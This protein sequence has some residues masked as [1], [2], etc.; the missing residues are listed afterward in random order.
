MA[1]DG[2][3]VPGRQRVEAA[4]VT[5]GKIG[6]DATKVS[7]VRQRAGAGARPVEPSLTPAR[8]CFI[9]NPNRTRPVG[10]RGLV[11]GFQAPAPEPN[12]RAQP[13]QT[14]RRPTPL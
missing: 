3:E 14:E 10:G 6:G 12:R 11:R 7:P 5:F 13:V 9:L 1:T 8:P 4:E 2:L